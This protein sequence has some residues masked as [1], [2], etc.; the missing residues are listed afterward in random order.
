MSDDAPLIP[1]RTRRLVSIRAGGRCEICG[2]RAAL[3]FHR[4]THERVGHERPDD[5][6]ALCPPCHTAAHRD[7]AGDTWD[8][9]DDMA[10]HWELYHHA[11]DKD[12]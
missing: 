9:V 2:E 8:N 7:P 3:E 11:M 12:D 1:A 5:V 6:L 10:A 4:T